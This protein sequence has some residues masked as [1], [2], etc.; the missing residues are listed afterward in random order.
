MSMC[1]AARY[2]RS[3]GSATRKL[4][5]GMNLPVAKYEPSPIPWVA[6][7]RE[8][9][10]VSE[11]RRRTPSGVAPHDWG[12]YDLAQI[13]AM[14]EPQSRASGVVAADAWSRMRT[15]CADE[16]DAIEGALSRLAER[17]PLTQP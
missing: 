16:A 6:D 5:T 1:R 12:R 17:W 2:L 7:V 3:I 15:L 8:V 4:S 9:G 10:N 14:L 11:G 13:W